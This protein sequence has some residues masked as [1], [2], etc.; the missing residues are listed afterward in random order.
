MDP[1]LAKL[2]EPSDTEAASSSIFKR[3]HTAA[4]KLGIWRIRIGLSSES[5][6][7]RLRQK[8]VD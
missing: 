8:D 5:D 4:Q 2:V 6:R 3:A 7:H 1:E